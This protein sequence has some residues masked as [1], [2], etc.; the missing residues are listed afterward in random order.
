MNWTGSLSWNDE[1]RRQRRQ[2]AK[3]PNR[4]LVEIITCPTCGERIK[5]RR[6]EVVG[7]T[8]RWICEAGKGC[9]NWKEDAAAGDQG[10]AH[11]A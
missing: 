3:P 1:E 11:L 2:S 5:I 10:R 6:K 9:D 7:P 4:V 8:S